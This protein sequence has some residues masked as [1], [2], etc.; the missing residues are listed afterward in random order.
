MAGPCLSSKP[1]VCKG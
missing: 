1:R